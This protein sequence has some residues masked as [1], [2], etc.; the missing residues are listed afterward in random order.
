MAGIRVDLRE[1]IPSVAPVVRGCLLRICMQQCSRTSLAGPGGGGTWASTQ[2]YSS[3]RH[4]EYPDGVWCV[5]VDV[6]VEIGGFVYE[7]HSRAD[8]TDG[9]G[10]EVDQDV[11]HQDKRA[12]TGV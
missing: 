6:H 2:S 9:P 5:S 3:P 4:T 7:K 1:R 12:R 8:V 11:Q 10:A